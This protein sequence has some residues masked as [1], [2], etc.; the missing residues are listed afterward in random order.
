MCAAAGSGFEASTG[1]ITDMI[2]AGVIDPVRVSHT[3]LRNAVSVA[4]LILTTHTLIADRPE[5][6]D[7]TSG[8]ALGGGAEMLGR[9]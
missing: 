1:K 2:A 9:A 5:H 7:P 6:L 4:A 8:A 3:A